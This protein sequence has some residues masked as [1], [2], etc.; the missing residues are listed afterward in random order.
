MKKLF[1][2]LARYMENHPECKRKT[3]YAI[4]NSYSAQNPHSIK[5]VKDV[6]I[7]IDYIESLKET[8]TYLITDALKEA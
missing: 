8:P 2:G 7:I 4:Y 1:I 3:S 5:S 6:K